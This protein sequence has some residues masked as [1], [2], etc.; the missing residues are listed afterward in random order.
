M[1]EPRFRSNRWPTL[2]V[3]VELQLVDA[4]SMGL[5]SAIGEILAGLPEALH[6]SVKPEFMQC[7][8]EINTGVCR[9]VDE[10]ESDLAPKIRAVEREADRHGVRLVWA[11]THPFSR[12]R[13]QQITPNDRYY[14]LAALLQETVVRPVTFGLHVHVGVDSGDRAI[15]VSHRIQ[16]FLPVLL[17]MSA[18][19]PFWHGRATGH[20]AHRIEVLEGFPTGG[21]M[22]PLHS[23]AEY[24]DLLGQMTAAGFVESHRE[25]WWDVRPNAEHGT[26]EI[27]ICDMPADL[28]DLLGLVAMIQCLVLSLSEEV[29]CAS[30][31]PDSG[32]EPHPLLLR[33]NR[34][35]ACRFGLEAE[36]VDPTTMEAQPARGAAE[37]LIRRLEA[38]A[39]RLGC[40]RSLGHALGMTVR[41][42]GSER[43]LLLYREVGDLAEVVRRMS[44]R[45][46]LSAEPAGANGFHGRV[47]GWSV[48]PIRPTLPPGVPV[49]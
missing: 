38:V 29:D 28:P 2:G 24:E 10:V 46:R 3:E 44:G 31:G 45:S 43:Q 33:Q 34:W 37:A 22:P 30:I 27:R 13:D 12:W 21:M 20:H 16:R 1:P 41:P 23:W 11:A 18:N 9:T 19:S 35:R 40:R 42:T 48:T 5:T 15:L 8:V 32:P 6:E 49:T 47:G 7:Y 4:R 36:L 25:L 14:K 17:A 26:I 39:D